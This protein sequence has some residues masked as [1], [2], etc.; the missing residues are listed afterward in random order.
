MRGLIIRAHI[1]GSVFSPYSHGKLN[2]DSI[3]ASASISGKEHEMP[4]LYHSVVS[5]DIP[6]LMCL[7]TDEDGKPLWA[8]SLLFPVTDIT[9]GKE[10]T[11]RRYPS[12]RADLSKKPSANTSAGQYKEYRKPIRTVQ[13]DEWVAY[14]IGDIGVIQELL[15]KISYVGSRR[16]AGYGRVQEWSVSVDDSVTIERIVKNRF[17]PVDALPFIDVVSENPTLISNPWTPPYHY[18]PWYS[19]C[20]IPDICS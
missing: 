3:L 14:A 7:W 6:G 19:S 15:S 18:S 12:H 17:V 10:Y 5:V 8:A 1:T 11:H 2:L 13:A 4:S 20:V 9:I 16:A